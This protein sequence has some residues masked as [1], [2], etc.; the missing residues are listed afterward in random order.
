MAEHT[1]ILRVFRI[2]ALALL[3]ILVTSAE[4]VITAH[5]QASSNWNIYNMYS[6]D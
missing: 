4:P 2:G 6:Q 3:Q 5:Q 1:W